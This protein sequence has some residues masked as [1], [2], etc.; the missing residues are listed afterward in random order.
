V[1]KIPKQFYVLALLLLCLFWRWPLWFGSFNWIV[2]VT[3]LQVALVISCNILSRDLWVT[4]IIA[5]E[6]FCMLFNVTLFYFDLH[7]L[8][9]QEQTMLVAFII[10]LLIITAS[11]GANLGRVTITCVHSNIKRLAS[12]FGLLSIGKTLGANT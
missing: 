9:I 8:A 5:I 7:R 6:F 11:M 4:L 1:S 12:R 2:T 10:E 3:M